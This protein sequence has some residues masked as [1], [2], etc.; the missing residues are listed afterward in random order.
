MKSTSAKLKNPPKRHL[1]A[2]NDAT[3]VVIYNLLCQLVDQFDI[4]Y[5]EQICRFYAKKDAKR[6]TQT[7]K[8]PPSPD[9]PAF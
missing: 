3:A 8:P 5:G 1:P 4:H 6:N 9:N 7:R 2:L